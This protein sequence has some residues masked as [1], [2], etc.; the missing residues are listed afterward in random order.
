MIDSSTLPTSREP[1][2]SDRTL[3]KQAYREA[4]RSW[5]SEIQTALKLF[6]EEWICSGF[7]EKGKEWPGRRDFAPKPCRADWAR[8]YLAGLNGEAGDGKPSLNPAPKALLAM[9]NVIGGTLLVSVPKG[10]EMRYILYAKDG[11]C[12]IVAPQ[13]GLDFDFIGRN[14]TDDPEEVAAGLFLTFFRSEW[15][16]S[17]MQCRKC[18]GFAVPSRKPRESYVRG[19]HCE[20]CRNSAAAQAATDERRKQFKEEWFPLAVEAYREFHSQTRRTSNNISVFIMEKVN[21]SLKNSRI[22]R[23]RITRNL[24]AIQ[25]KAALKEG[26]PDAQG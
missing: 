23:K 24:K 20:K 2:I 8:N 1:D 4:F 13:G 3:Y 16:F 14:N 19:W 25:A 10:E 7:D 15:L 5:V 21:I 22:K 9:Q 11:I 17:L 26:C 12:V 6:I 18:K